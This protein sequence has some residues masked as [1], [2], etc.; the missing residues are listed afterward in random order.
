MIVLCVPKEYVALLCGSGLQQ[1][2][3]PD[4]RT[5]MERELFQA[6]NMYKTDPLEQVKAAW[7]A[8]DVLLK[9]WATYYRLTRYRERFGIESNR[10][11]LKWPATAGFIAL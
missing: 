8:D 4:W 6:A 5:E 3:L 10:F 2:R 11:D 9:S 1:D 7:D